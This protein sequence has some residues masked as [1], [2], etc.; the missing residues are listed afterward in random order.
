MT[1]KENYLKMLREVNA[2]QKRDDAAKAKAAEIIREAKSKGFKPMVDKEIQYGLY[3]VDHATIWAI[4]N[5][6]YAPYMLFMMPSTIVGKGLR[7]MMPEFDM[8]LDEA[9]K[10]ED[11]GQPYTASE[12]AIKHGISLADGLFGYLLNII[13]WGVV[14]TIIF[15]VQW[16]PIYGKNQVL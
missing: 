4:K 14:L 13:V 3:A 12:Y 9:K 10:I 16:V 7:I 11:G 5:G 6:I 8:I 15:P 2:K 1:K